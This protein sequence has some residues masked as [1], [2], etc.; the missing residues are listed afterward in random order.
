MPKRSWS[1]ALATLSKVGAGG[2]E[3]VRLTDNTVSVVD[4]GQMWRLDSPVTPGISRNA[5]STVSMSL[6][7]G[8]AFSD[9]SIVSLRR[10]QVCQKIIAARTIETTGAIHLA[11]V[12]QMTAPAIITP[13]ET[14]ASA[15]M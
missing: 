1:I 6:P 2:P 3:S 7:R 4:I 10:P 5:F 9:I 14:V 11:P 12:N 13:A 8:T 15:A